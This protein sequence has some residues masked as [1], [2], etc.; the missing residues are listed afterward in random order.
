MDVKL[1]HHIPLS[2]AINAGRTC[3]DSHC[4]GGNYSEPTDKLVKDDVEFLDRILN[5]H[6]HQ[7]VGEHISYSF[8]IEGLSRAAL[9]ELARHRLASYSVKSSRYTLKELK[10]EE[11]FQTTLYSMESYKSNYAERVRKY[12]LLVGDYAD[13]FPKTQE[14]K[15]VAIDNASIKALENL[16]E[17]ISNGASMDLA[18]YAMPE[19]YRTTVSWS[20][21]YRSLRNFLSLRSSPAALWEMRLL[22]SKILEALPKEHLFLYDLNEGC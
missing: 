9:Q 19:S 3:W 6:K 15:Y 12:I 1:R 5:K 13:R 7:S 11:P 10:N 16:R 4:K 14:D 18:K 22:S 17:I 8:V 21:N 2:I 20:I